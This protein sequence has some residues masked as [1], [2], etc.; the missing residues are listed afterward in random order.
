[1]VEQDTYSLALPFWAA[2]QLRWT[3]AVC[4]GCVLECH[5]LAVHLHTSHTERQLMHFYHQAW[6]HLQDTGE[7]LDSGTAVTQTPDSEEQ[8]RV[9]L[10]GNT[11]KENKSGCDNV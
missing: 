4:D 3:T 6:P 7:T 8:G 1:M 5:A 9:L 11:K 10:T 2:L